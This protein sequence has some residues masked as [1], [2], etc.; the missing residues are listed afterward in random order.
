VPGTGQMG[1]TAAPEALAGDLSRSE[2]RYNEIGA[3]GFPRSASGA[4]S[5]KAKGAAVGELA[6]LLLRPWGFAPYEALA[7]DLSGRSEV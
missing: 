3:G 6:Y 5:G 7:G 2:R 4:T 1:G